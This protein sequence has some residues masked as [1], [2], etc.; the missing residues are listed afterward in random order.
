VGFRTDA[1]SE[2]VDRAMLG[3]PGAPKPG[4]DDTNTNRGKRR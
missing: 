1:P 4:R 2:E 3:M